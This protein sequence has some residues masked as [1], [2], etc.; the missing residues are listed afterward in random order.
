M[1]LRLFFAHTWPSRKRRGGPEAVDTRGRTGPLPGGSSTPLSSVCPLGLPNNLGRPPPDTLWSPRSE[2]QGPPR[3]LRRLTPHCGNG[4]ITMLIRSLS[5]GERRGTSSVRFSPPFSPGDP[6]K[7]PACPP[8][9]VAHP[10]TAVGPQRPHP[11]RFRRVRTLAH[12]QGRIVVPPEVSPP[13]HFVAALTGRPWLPTPP[14][15]EF[16]PMTSVRG[17]TRTGR[18]WFRRT[19]PFET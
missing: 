4:L 1:T 6:T 11:Q 7:H 2:R 3:A 12:M 17:R 16:E 9:I 18:I 13:G 19:S 5:T 15:G 8:W 14:E 10:T